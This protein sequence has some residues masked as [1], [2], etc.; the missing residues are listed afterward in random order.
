VCL[1]PKIDHIEAARSFEMIGPRAYAVKQ[2]LTPCHVHE[3]LLKMYVLKWLTPAQ[4][5]KR[6]NFEE[7]GKRV[8]KLMEERE[9]KRMKQEQEYE[10]K[11]ELDLRA[12]FLRAYHM[13]RAAQHLDFERRNSIAASLENAAAANINDASQERSAVRM[14]FEAAHLPSEEHVRD[15]DLNNSQQQHHQQ[16][17]EEEVKEEEGEEEDARMLQSAQET[18]AQARE[19]A[20]KTQEA[21]DNK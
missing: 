7:E 16:E 4:K 15:G 11:S 12:A 6:L 8:E 14:Q 3:K 19:A 1:P 2:Q 18:A 13:E 17:E 5:L 21:G 9:L 10:A 20:R